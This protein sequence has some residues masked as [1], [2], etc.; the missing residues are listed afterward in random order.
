[1]AALRALRQV[2]VAAFY[3]VGGT[4]LLPSAQPIR[5]WT[6]SAALKLVR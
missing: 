3:R 1:M 6:A 4:H 2:E 5:V